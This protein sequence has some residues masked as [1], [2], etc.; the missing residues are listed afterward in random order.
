MIT[1]EGCAERPAWK[2]ALAIPWRRRTRRWKAHPEGGAVPRA[3][4]GLDAAAVRGDHLPDQRQA[5]PEAAAAARVGAAGEP[6]E[7]VVGD[8]LVEPGAVV[9][10]LQHRLRTPGEH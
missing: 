9:A 3:A 6:I 4:M 2:S 1:A 7:Q 5:Q 8:G 10:D